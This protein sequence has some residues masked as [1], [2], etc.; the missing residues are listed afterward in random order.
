MKHRT[1]FYSICVSPAVAAVCNRHA[2][3]T[4]KTSS[5]PA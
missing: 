1:L 2:N 4:L 5:Y 3:L